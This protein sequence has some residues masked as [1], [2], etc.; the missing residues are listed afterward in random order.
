MLFLN[1]QLS[2][3]WPCMLAIQLRPKFDCF[4]YICPIRTNKSTQAQP[5]G[6]R[7]QSIEG[8][9]TY[10][11]ECL[12]ANYYETVYY[13]KALLQISLKKLYADRS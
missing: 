10:I 4:N 3:K 13:L 12:S 8:C 5:M 2:I 6:E 11:P 1:E 7:A 9:K